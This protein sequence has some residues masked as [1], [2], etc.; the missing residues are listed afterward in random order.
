[1]IVLHPAR[2]HP[3]VASGPAVS[4]ATESR[5]LVVDGYVR[6]TVHHCRFATRSEVDR[7]HIARWATAR[8]WRVR[9]VFEEPG[10]TGLADDGSLLREALERVESHESDG[11]VVARVTHLGAS[12][13][14]AI[15]ALERL[16]AAGGRFVSVCDEIDLGTPTGRLILRLL[17][18]MLKW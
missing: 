9:G 10:S 5:P 3:V 11:L 16:H 2:A 14:D 17:F 7:A 12:L 15:A 18:S 13:A 1:V 8:G 6:S 4:P